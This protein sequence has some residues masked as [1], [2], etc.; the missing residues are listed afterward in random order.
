[1]AVSL[2]CITTLDQA[3]QYANDGY[4]SAQSKCPYSVS[5][6][7]NAASLIQGG[8]LS[9]E[10]AKQELLAANNACRIELGKVIQGM[11]S[12]NGASAS[13]DLTFDTDVITHSEAGVVPS[14]GGSKIL[15][16][17]GIG[18]GAY[19]LLSYLSKKKKR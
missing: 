16:Y 15:L 2:G 13:Q 7:S 1:M 9:V 3:L 4:N 10:D 11:P 19:F 14:G 5:A 12:C 18:V 6:Y 17:L 8:D